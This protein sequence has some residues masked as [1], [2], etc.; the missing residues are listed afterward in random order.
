[1]YTDNCLFASEEEKKKIDGDVN[2]ICE[3]IHNCFKGEG[4]NV[5][6]FLSGSLARREPT[7]QVIQGRTELAS[8]LDF[9]LVYDERICNY[10]SVCEIVKRIDKKYEKYEC[11]FVILE[12][13]KL[14]NTNSF[15]K[16]DL[17]LDNYGG[18]FD[19]IGIDKSLWGECKLSN[20]NAFEAIVTQAC[21]YL[22]NPDLSKDKSENKFF[23]SANYHKVKLIC[24]CF[25]GYLF[26][27]CDGIVGYNEALKNIH[28]IPETYRP[29]V[30]KALKARE[31][32][33]YGLVKDIN[34]LDIVDMSCKKILGDEYCEHML[35][36]L[37]KGLDGIK[38]FQY[39]AILLFMLEKG[40]VTA[41][42]LLESIRNGNMKKYYDTKTLET[43]L[44]AYKVD[45]TIDNKE[46]LY[47]VFRL[48][49]NRFVAYLHG[50]NTGEEFCT[51]VVINENI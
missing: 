23:K 2:A 28:N 30:E 27:L 16:R 7:H 3:D 42:D 49:R 19:D 6:L 18:I 35:S 48:V 36:E 15:F 24:E 4:L 41:D 43:A 11:S 47:V 25:R 50:R 33:D 12:T 1:M 5:A 13:K 20:H 26:S 39:T 31:C 17:S 9:V 32:C 21:C 40:S 34:V 14:K 44:E 22:L 29:A 38:S 46:N 51:D 45:K 10:E 8:D 37:R